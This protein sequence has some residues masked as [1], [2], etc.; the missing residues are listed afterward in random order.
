MKTVVVAT[1]NQHKAEEINAILDISGWKF[2]TLDEL[3][4]SDEPVE[5]AD[6]FEG[7]ARIK[8]QFA[9]QLTGL[10]AI[11]D[12]SGLMVDALDGEPGIYSSRY[13]GEPSNDQANNNKLLEKLHGLPTG[14]RT[15]RFI[16]SIVFIDSD[17]SELT[18]QGEFKGLI[19]TEPRG[20]MGFG[21]DPLFLPDEFNGQR[22]LAELTPAEKN[23]ISH[24]AIVLKKL[25]PQLETLSLSKTPIVVFDYDGTLIDA[26][27]P[28][29]LISRLTRDR[30]MPKRVAAKSVLWGARYKLGNELDQ[31]VPRRYI[32]SSF[33]DFPATD[34]NAIMYNLYHEDLQR[35]LRPQGLQ[36]IKEHQK[37]GETIVIVSASFEPIIQEL[38]KDVNASAYICT[39]MEVIDGAYTGETIGSPPEGEQK[40]I[41]FNDWA[42]QTYGKGGWELTWAYGDH[43]SDVPLMETA[44]NPVAIDPDRRLESIAKKRGWQMFS[45]PFKEPLKE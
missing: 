9:H 6:S 24:R 32:F 23:Q 44:I 12:D 7:N 42:N 4:I 38:V 3:G 1:H 16:C 15:A 45:W 33:K 17:G 18:A 8:A 14:Q 19:G 37:A 35:Y 20:T 5:D 13:A 30:I 22:T 41:Q 34:A 10:A 28:V 39:K 21:Y 27:S 26:S 25:K 29:R 11:A 2:V 40:L 36:R 31:S 43:Y